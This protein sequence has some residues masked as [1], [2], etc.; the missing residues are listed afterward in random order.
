MV[1]QQTSPIVLH[2]SRLDAADKSWHL[3]SPTP[4]DPPITYGGFNQSRALGLRI[5][6]ILDTR[7]QALNA[8]SKSP[9]NGPA[10]IKPRRKK[11]KVYIHSSPF[12]RCVQ[13]SI[14]IS[15][16]LAQYQSPSSDKSRS[17]AR[18][19]SPHSFRPSPR[20]HAVDDP[21]RALRRLGTEQNTGH[22]KPSLRIDAF[23]GEWLSPDYF[24]MIT[25][26]PNSVLMVAGAKA[27]LLRK[28]E[29]I[30]QNALSPNPQTTKTSASN[31][32]GNNNGSQPLSSS[33]PA[34]GKE[35]QGQMDMKSVQ[36]SLPPVPVRRDRAWSSAA[37]SSSGRSSSFGR[38]GNSSLNPEPV[39]PYTPPTPHYA[40]AATEPIPKGYV[41][42]A[43]DACVETD[44]QWDSMR[45][46]LLWG[47]GGEYG[48]EWSEMHRR[49]RHGLAT[50]V[51]FYSHGGKATDEQEAVAQAYGDGDADDEENTEVV[52]IMVTHG[53]GC[54]A[55]LGALTDQPVLLDV[56]MASLSMAVRKDAQSIGRPSGRPNSPKLSSESAPSDLQKAVQSASA[57]LSSLYEMKLI[58]SAEHLRPGVD[59]SRPIPVASSSPILPASKT[60]PDSRRRSTLAT[61]AA[62]GSPMSMDTQWVVPN[63]DSGRGNMS[64]ALGSMRRPSQAATS[65]IGVFRTNSVGST[66]S[67]TGLWTPNTP[68]LTEV[69]REA[70]FTSDP[71]QPKKDSIS[72]DILELSPE[73][74]RLAATGRDNKLGIDVGNIDQK[75][76]NPTTTDDDTETD[77]LRDLPSQAPPQI[78][79]NLSQRGLWG[80]S[81]A[82]AQLSRERGPKR[83][84][85]VQQE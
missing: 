58:A 79:R 53:A 26:P 56:G 40:I 12:Q 73:A 39:K 64:A 71:S 33:T 25:P 11:H 2:G 21:R 67:S 69:D 46:P 70:S 36:Q 81:P 5:A 20:L 75:M 74:E 66:A 32:W 44:Y 13:T 63:S 72:A 10:S 1:G 45:A 61:H 82:G 85:T 59:P 14:G 23:L 4:Y 83:R 57:G 8:E 28:G 6:N 15:A 29:E 50:M 16:G 37:S 52:V 42:H 30:D 62:S 51:E 65:T 7:E 3:R 31:L 9:E 76:A 35:G 38:Q 34:S 41:A 77:V 54:N 49:F 48:E 68:P 55:L 19:R 22:N 84:W 27:D 78:T 17:D 18:A 60:I 47:T 80:S 43:R 24:E